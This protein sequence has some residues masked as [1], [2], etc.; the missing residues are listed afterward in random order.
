MPGYSQRIARLWITE[1]I[2]GADGTEVRQQESVG[3]GGCVLAKNAGRPVP[4]NDGDGRPAPHS[5]STDEI[6]AGK[7][8]RMLQLARVYVLIGVV[9]SRFDF[10]CP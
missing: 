9:S 2:C 1:N 8:R 6:N 7:E 5:Q 10:A 4:K 3:C